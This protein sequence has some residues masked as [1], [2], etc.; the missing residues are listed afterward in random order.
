M[1]LVRLVQVYTATVHL[2]P[3]YSERLA[4]LLIIAIAVYGVNLSMR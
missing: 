4:K 3:A 2:M 1:R